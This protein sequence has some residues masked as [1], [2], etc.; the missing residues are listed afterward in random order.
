ML[1]KFYSLLAHGAQS[2]E[3][4]LS[5]LILLSE[6]I[7]EEKS[8]LRRQFVASYMWGEH[9][10][11]RIKKTNRRTFANMWGEWAYYKAL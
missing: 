6:S 11:R 4:N 7:L 3:H 10:Q 2:Q 8:K 5:E 9:L 1:S